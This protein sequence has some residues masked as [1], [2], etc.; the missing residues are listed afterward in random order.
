MPTYKV[1][2][3]GEISV[4]LYVKAPTDDFAREGAELHV[5]ADPLGYIDF[6]SFVKEV[7]DNATVDIDYTEGLV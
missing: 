4:T 3:S 1:T 5:L 6:D 7:D 2:V